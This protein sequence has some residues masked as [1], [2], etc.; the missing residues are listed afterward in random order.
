[1]NG[2]LAL[3]VQWCKSSSSLPSAPA[4]VTLRCLLDL[5]LGPAVGPGPGGPQG[6]HGACLCLRP[7]HLCPGPP[8]PS[9]QV[10]LSKKNTPPPLNKDI[11]ED[12]RGAGK[13]C[14][15]LSGKRVER[16][17]DRGLRDAQ[18]ADRR[19]VEGH[20][21]TLQRKEPE[22]AP[23]KNGGPGGSDSC[24]QRVWPP[25]IRASKGVCLH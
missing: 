5:L 15:L 7:R 2:G 18:G 11:M 16:N 20:T 19:G 1:M 14:K 21:G 4:A 13:S 24:E 6:P 22:M 12:L 10:P 9:H 8:H 23:G 17:G 3:C 25:E